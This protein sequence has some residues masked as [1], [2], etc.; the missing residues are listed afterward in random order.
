MNPKNLSRAA[1]VLVVREG[2]ILS[3]SRK[4]DAAVP[5]LP[6][7]KVEE[8]ETDA[9]AAARECFEETGLVV[10]GL[11]HLYSGEDGHGYW[12]TTFLAHQFSGQPRDMGQGHVEW[13]KPDELLRGEFAD[14]NKRML[15]AWRKM[16]LGT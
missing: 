4:H 8:G 10:G 9:H 3:V 1:C 5:G 14:Y 6:G 12:C 15:A 13:I 2:R 16:M 11:R 7:G